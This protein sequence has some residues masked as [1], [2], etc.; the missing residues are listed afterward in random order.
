MLVR[1][2]LAVSI[3]AGTHCWAHALGPGPQEPIQP[4][5]GTAQINAHRI[6]NAVHSAGRQWG[7]SVNHNGLSFFPVVMPKGTLLYHGSEANA[8]PPGPEWLAFEVEHAEAFALSLEPL[9]KEQSQT[10]LGDTPQKPISRAHAKRDAAGYIRG[11][12]HTY[13]AKRDLNLVYVDGMSAGKTKMGTLDSQD[14]V[15]R[16]NNTGPIWDGFMDELQ[17]ASSICDLVKDWG[18]DGFMRMEIGFEVVYCDF[19]VGV[20]L[21]SIKRTSLRKDK[22]IEELMN[23]YQWARAVTERYDG[24]G[25][26]RVRIDFSSMVSAFWFPVNISN[27]DPKRPDLPRLTAAKPDE[28]KAIKERVR[29]VFT[30][31][32]R[33]TVNWQAV[34]DMVVTRFSNR[35]ALMA[36]PDLSPMSFILELDVASLTYFDAPPLPDDVSMA[37]QNTRNR[38]LEAID[39][40]TE[41]YLLPAYL[42]RGEWSPEDK[43]IHTAFKTVTSSI[44]QCLY[45]MRS[46]MGDVVRNNDT[47]DASSGSEDLVRAVNASRKLLYDLREQLAWTTWKRPQVCAVDEILLMVMWPLGNSEDYWNPGCRPD[48]DV[49][50][51]RRGYWW[52]GH[53]RQA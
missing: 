44:C 28:W 9:G 7:S 42:D 27:T 34:A 13:R 38:T 50:F 29:D 22:D 52:P 12:F 36:S 18:Y 19:A 21:I 49:S 6:F 46:V 30:R 23:P 16:E 10:A 1:S 5:H 3:V 43:L 4:D 37:H 15:L 41:H 53:E 8:T 33:F 40:C 51:R 2:T 35:F 14:L 47:A 24:I 25:G 20:D 26:D 48:S 39:A 31:P 11:Y 17:R 32:R 45:A